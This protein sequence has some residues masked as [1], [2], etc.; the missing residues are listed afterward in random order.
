MWSRVLI[1]QRRHGAE[2][3]PV[4]FWGI[5]CTREKEWEGK[6]KL[7]KLFLTCGRSVPVKMN[8]RTCVWGSFVSHLGLMPPQDSSFF[9]NLSR[10]KKTQSFIKG[11]D[12][13]PFFS[14]IERNS[15][16]LSLLL[17]QMKFIICKF[18][19]SVSSFLALSF[20]HLNPTSFLQYCAKLFYLPPSTPFHLSNRHV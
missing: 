14:F 8:E 3:K 13:P 1:L 20:P 10:C 4:L 11:V 7:S 9:C 5:S 18:T 19:S 12:I 6:R 16:E 15:L 2:K 17:D